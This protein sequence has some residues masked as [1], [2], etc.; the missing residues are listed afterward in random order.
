METQTRTQTR[1]EIPWGDDSRWAEFDF[2]PFRPDPDTGEK[3]PKTDYLFNVPDGATVRDALGGFFI[4]I[5]DG[6][7][8]G[9]VVVRRG[10]LFAQFA[11]DQLFQIRH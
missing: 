6:P 2:E 8:Q 4:K 7:V 11:G 9:A 3:P 10:D 1:T 5:T